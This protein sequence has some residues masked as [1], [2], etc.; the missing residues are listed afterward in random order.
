MTFATAFVSALAIFSQSST[1]K[2]TTSLGAS[3]ND[4]PMKVPVTC[5]PSWPCPEGSVCMRIVGKEGF[6]VLEVEY[7]N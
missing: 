4:I 7:G 5:S 1:S 2:T 6:C 3:K